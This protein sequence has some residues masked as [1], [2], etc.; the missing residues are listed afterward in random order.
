MTRP[1]GEDFQRYLQPTHF[2]DFNAP[3]VVEFAQQ[4]MGGA[5][6]DLEKAVK[7]YYAVRDGIRYDPYAMSPDPDHYRASWIVAAPSGFC[8]QKALLLASVA[9]LAGIPSRLGY[10]DV[11][12]HLTSP[13]LREL[14][15]TDLFV[16]HGYTEL[17]LDGR[18]L[19]ATPVF[20]SSLCE[21]FGVLPLEF[22]GR[23][24]SIL[25]PYDA[26]NRRHME[27]VRDHGT[28][29]DLP[30][31]EMMRAFREAYPI[32]ST[33]LE[34]PAAGDPLFGPEEKQG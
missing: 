33:G 12:N 1:S 19:K 23:S 7:L 20:N 8:V 25:H 30:F 26:R 28:F 22:D 18:W 2:L 13:K 11:R 21:R 5:V 24:D 9:R 6:T 3:A 15:Q 16:F 32:V 10:A 14:M 17:W 27:Y 29:D 31:G 4:A 34:V